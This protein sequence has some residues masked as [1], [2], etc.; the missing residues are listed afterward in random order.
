M[1][2]SKKKVKLAKEIFFASIS[3][4]WNLENLG[5]FSFFPDNVFVDVFIGIARVGNKQRGQVNLSL[6]SGTRKGFAP[7]PLI[8][9]LNMMVYVVCAY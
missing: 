6:V 7:L 2:Q 8:T 5:C 1:K 4:I 9:T 3:C